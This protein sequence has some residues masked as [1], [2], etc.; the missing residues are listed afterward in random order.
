ML[1][2]REII[3]LMKQ[4]GFAPNAPMVYIFGTAMLSAGLFPNLAGVLL[5][6]VLVF[7]VS[8]ETLS[9]YHRQMFRL[10]STLWS[11]VY[12]AVTILTFILIRQT[13]PDDTT[14][15]IFML[16]LL[17]MIWGN[18]S[19]AFFGGR[20]FGRHLMAPHLSPKKTWEGFAFGFL[21]A[22]IGLYLVTV[23]YPDSMV[24]LSGF[25]PL[26]I[27]ISIFGPIGDLLASKIKR[28]AGA[29][30]SSRL[31]PGHGGFLDR[32][33]SILLA[34]PVMYIYLRLFIL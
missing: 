7:L 31:L 17:L 1:I 20:T 22:A 2:H 16:A 13:G 18:D 3:E 33:D 14:G 27:L 11:S 9:K 21:G 28:A 15:F 6:A 5:L 26:I 12:P 8:I 23:L 34:S 29:K 25:W 30:D 32:F 19:L 4:Q 24:T 10:M